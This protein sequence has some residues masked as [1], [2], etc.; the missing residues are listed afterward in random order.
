MPEAHD[1]LPEAAH[2]ASA[3]R[4]AVEECVQRAA[5][6]A[7]TVVGAAGVLVAIVAAVLTVVW[8]AVPLSVLAVGAAL[9]EY[10][11][12]LTAGP[13]EVLSSLVTRPPTDAER[14][15]FANAVDG[16]RVRLGVPEPRL[17][18]VDHAGVNA[19]VAAGAD[20]ADAD[21]VVTSGLLE[22]VPR[23]GLEAVVA[24]QLALVR[25]GGARAASVA[26]AL[27]RPWLSPF[28]AWVRDGLGPP[29]PIEAD[30][31]AAEVTRY[32]PGLVAAL[33]TAAGRDAAV[34][35][36]PPAAAA[37]WLVPQSDGGDLP[38]IGDR[39]AVLREL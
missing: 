24:R 39:T 12:V 8:L 37:L 17:A 5:G 26:A 27:R 1:H 34:P 14:P 23:L 33:E 16:V 20:D 2:D 28:G 15:R 11:R 22:S 7:A 13:G 32:P 4:A 9:A 21:L 30:L 36:A 38:R 35:G 6:R 31:T 18:V 3:R 19:V 29:D 10:R 25:H